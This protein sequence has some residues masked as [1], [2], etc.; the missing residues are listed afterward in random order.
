MPTFH[1]WS[2]GYVATCEAGDPVYH[3][4]AEAATLRE[5]CDALAARD[6]EFRR[7]YDA[8]ALTH[9]SC[10]LYAGKRP[11]SSG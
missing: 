8:A 9:W 5:A 7:Y 2:E 11:R 1:V 10:R 3:G 4:S 6:R